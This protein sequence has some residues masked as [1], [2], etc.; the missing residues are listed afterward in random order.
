MIF[1]WLSIALF[2]RSKKSK[3]LDDVNSVIDYFHRLQD[4]SLEVHGISRNKVMVLLVEAFAI[5]ASLGSEYM[6]QDIEYMI[7]LCDELKQNS[8][9]DFTNKAHGSLIEAII[10]GSFGEASN[11]PSDKSIEI[12][13]TASLRSL[14][15]VSHFHSHLPPLLHPASMKHSRMI[16]TRRQLRY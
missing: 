11:R 7:A 2:R 10:N 16:I 12:L 6:T 5:R 4:Y 9:A 1:F 8:S 15:S 3:R 14:Q 13:R